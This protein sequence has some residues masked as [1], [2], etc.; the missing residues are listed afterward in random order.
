MVRIAIPR[1]MSYYYLYP[2]FKTLLCEM[3]AEV[4]VSSPTTKTTLENM[5]VC[6]TDEPCVA[7]KLY[8]AHVKELMNQDYE[9]IFLPK[10]ISL[11]QGTYC[12]PKFIGIPDM[13]MTTFKERKRILSPR[14][15]VGSRKLM[16][17]DM[18]QIG[19]KLGIKRH[20]VAQIV[21][22]AWKEQENISKLMIKNQI[23]T[24]EA[25]ETFDNVIGD[26]AI[27]SNSHIQEESSVIGVVGHPYVLYEWVSHDIVKRFRE[28][29][30][31]ITPEMV[32]E[33]NIK[34]QMGHIYEGDKMWS[35]EAQVL[36]SAL[37]LIN[38]K[39]IDKLV[40]V[41][42]FECGPESIIEAYVENR[43]DEIGIPLLK[44][45]MDDQTGEA[46]LLTRIEAFMDT[47]T[48]DTI[49][50]IDNQDNTN[51]I[52]SIST[53]AKNIDYSCKN[54]V[55]GFPSM[56]NLDI[57]VHSVLR[58][59]GMN[60]VK[61]PMIS[62]HTIELGKELAPEFVCLPLPCSRGSTSNNT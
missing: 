6:P 61:P 46:G 30:R 54:Q 16:L 51:M 47:N 52:S 62:K 27:L 59:C 12:C 43:A 28:Y 7:V 23:T 22:N 32:D 17:E 31:V 56:G 20:K 36:G 11:E 14:I 5:S 34:E 19:Q 37:Y 10:I 38:N 4:V 8:F 40:L 57:V 60:V 24:D 49:K 35:F 39:L 45:Y 15:D 58:E 53:A 21:D 2:F 9:F 41:G 29:G 44:L 42:L 50:D 33:K 25:Y 26:R 48:Q 18:I 55:I 1:A 3:G 13:V